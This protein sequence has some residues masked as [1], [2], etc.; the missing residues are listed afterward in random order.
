MKTSLTVFRD[1]YQEQLLSLLWRQWTA[2]GVAG[3]TGRSDKSLVDPEALLLM[4]CGLG[5]RDPRLFDE[6]LDWLCL[7]DW[8]INVQRLANVARTETWSGAPVLA[9]VAGFMTTQKTQALKWKRLAR[10]PATFPPAEE[11]FQFDDGKP[12]PVLGEPESIFARYGFQRGPLRLRGYS[13]VFRPLTPA[14]LLLQ[15]RALFGLA[16]RAEVIAYL[17]THE[18]GHAAGIARDTCYHK[19]SVQET[20][21]QLHGTGIV[22]VRAEGREKLYRVEVAPWLALLCRNAPLPQWINWPPLWS[23]LDQIWLGL[24]DPR[25]TGLE[26]LMQASLLRQLMVAVRPAIER[27]GFDKVLSDDRHYL[28]EAY[29]PVFLSDITKLLDALDTNQHE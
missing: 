13:R 9:A 28:A 5:R 26:P 7:N 17:L 11:L 18:T 1:N 22:G 20:L 10:L 23:A 8:T 25:L 14:A 21:L 27:A 15:L 4:T 16:V 6:M 2:L 12:L 19:K 3:A 24:N 29:L